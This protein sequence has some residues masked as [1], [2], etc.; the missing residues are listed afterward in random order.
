MASQNNKGLTCKKI[1]DL[2]GITT[3]TLTEWIFDHYTLRKN[4]EN[5][6]WKLN[7]KKFTPKQVETLFEYLG[8]PRPYQELIQ[9]KDINKYSEK[10]KS[11]PIVPINREFEDLR[12]KF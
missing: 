8:D 5:H 9:E 2:Y 7:N 12:D 10:C 1:A 6:S 4:L 11:L 3:E